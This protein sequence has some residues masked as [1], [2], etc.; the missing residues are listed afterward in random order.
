[1]RKYVI[2]NIMLFIVEWKDI[3]N[4]IPVNAGKGLWKNVEIKPDK[5]FLK[6]CKKY[7]IL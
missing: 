7:E 5:N 3:N 6:K 1:M 4:H 2:K